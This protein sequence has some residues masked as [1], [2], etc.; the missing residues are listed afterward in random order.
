MKI[1]KRYEKGFESHCNLS[2]PAMIC[3]LLKVVGNHRGKSWRVPIGQKSE[4]I[5]LPSP[6]IAWTSEISRVGIHRQGST[7]L[8]FSGSMIV[9]F[10]YACSRRWEHSCER[11]GDEN[12]VMIVQDLSFTGVTFCM[13][14][15]L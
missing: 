1:Q 11:E 8:I 7:L 13:A 15:D 2:S 4:K 9:L 6:A 12:A 5:T 10:H 3:K 14:Q